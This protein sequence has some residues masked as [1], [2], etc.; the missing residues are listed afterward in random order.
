MQADLPDAVVAAAQKHLRLLDQALPKRCIAYG[1]VG[2][3]ALGDYQPHHSDLDFVA[4]LAAPPDATEREHLKRLSEALAR[5]PEGKAFDG[6]YVWPELLR[7]PPDGQAAPYLFEGQFYP[8]KAFAANPI[9]W[10]T[11]AK[12]PCWLRCQQPL[13]IWQD[14]SAVKAWC[15]ANLQSYWQTWLTR[16]RAPAQAHLPLDAETLQ[17]CVLGIVRL[18]ATVYSGQILS[19][20]AAGAYALQ[21]FS[22]SYKPLIQA[23]LNARLQGAK[24]QQLP[25]ASRSDAVAFM[26]T[27]YAQAL[28]YQDVG[29]INPEQDPLLT[30]K[31]G[32]SATAPGK[33]P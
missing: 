18:H 16:L 24:A 26:Q 8:D 9:S 19:K 5:L 25:L 22:A 10:L 28:A 1:F 17:W 23:A 7:A 14:L 13:Q 15:L 2:S 12:Y 31:G 6:L 11:L 32:H 33:M 21:A 4:V 27:V 3:L 30:N 29:L 20:S